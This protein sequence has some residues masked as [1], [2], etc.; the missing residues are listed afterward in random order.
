MALLL[1]VL[2]FADRMRDHPPFGL[3]FAFKEIDAVLS[4]PQTQWMVLLCLAMYFSAFHVLCSRSDLNMRRVGNPNVWL[5]CLLAVSG[6]LY[7]VHYFHR[8]RHWLC[9]VARR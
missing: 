6:V 4:D 8:R 1:C 3:G 9:W 7:A 2:L 5:G